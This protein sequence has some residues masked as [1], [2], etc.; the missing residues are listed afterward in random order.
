LHELSG[1]YRTS[2]IACLVLQVGAAVLVLIRHGR[3]PIDA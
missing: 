3:K 1:D 2:L